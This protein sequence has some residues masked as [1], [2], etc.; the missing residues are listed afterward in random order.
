MK[1]N[2]SET[3]SADWGLFGVPTQRET[4]QIVILPV[5]WEVTTSYGGGAAGGPQ[6]VRHASPQIDLFDLE[7]G[8]VYKNGFHLENPSSELEELNHLLR[9][10]ALD[11]RRE[12]EDNGALSADRQKDLETIN[13]GCQKMVAW[14]KAESTRILQAGKIPAVLG[15]DHSTPQGLIQ[16]LSEHH[17]KPFGVLHL[18]AHADL[19]KAYQGFHHSHASIMYNVMSSSWAPRRLV[20]VGI[21]DFSREEYE[22]TQTDSRI[23]TF[24]DSG[25]KRALFAGRSWNDLCDE[26]LEDLPSEVYV[27]F[28]I[29]GLSP[30]LC[31]S[32]GTPVP[33]GLSFAE[34]Q[35]LLFKL[36]DS[37]R[38]IIGFDLNEVAPGSTEWD[39]NVGARMLYKLCG[40]T[41]KSWLFNR[42]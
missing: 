14:V 24:F 19:R 17:K 18:D 31:P 5:P 41:S 38:K 42:S 4:A 2:P 7:F 25:L 29:D 11:V 12:L 23:K 16:A 33:G 40:W 37:G 36:V 3:G 9:P 35:Y 1:F 30:D 6:A 20:Q 26:I 13:L 32:T 27:S 39:A 34:A 21:R 15:G 10:L 8:E 28:D 22:L